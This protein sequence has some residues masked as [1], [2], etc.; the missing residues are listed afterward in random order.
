MIVRRPVKVR[1]KCP[2]QGR[3]TTSA[4][5]ARQAATAPSSSARIAASVRSSKNPRS[6]ASRGGPAGC[7]ASSSNQAP[8]IKAR[9]P[10][11]RAIEP[12]VSRLGASGTIPSTGSRAEDAG[13]QL[14]TPQNDAGLVSDPAVCEPS[15]ARHIPVA[16]AAAE[17]LEEPPGVRSSFHGFRVGGG[18]MNA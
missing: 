7:S 3:S 8:W 17:P 16:T 4:P 1:S 15:A 6:R 10:T 9:S 14:A 12:I 18:S 13:F 2:G 11:V 5:A